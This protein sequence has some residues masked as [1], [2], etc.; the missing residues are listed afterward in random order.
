MDPKEIFKALMSSKTQTFEATGNMLEDVL[1]NLPEED[2]DFI[3]YLVGEL[4]CLG[5]ELT[6]MSMVEALMELAP[7]PGGMLNSVS[8]N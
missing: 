3:I 5:S 8:M 7:A 2:R 4:L 1:G 6:E